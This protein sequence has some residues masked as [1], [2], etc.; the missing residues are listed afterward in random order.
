MNTSD[1]HIDLL[2]GGHATLQTDVPDEIAAAATVD[3]G[4]GVIVVSPEQSAVSA[5]VVAWRRT[6][7]DEDLYPV[8]ILSYIPVNEMGTKFEI[9]ILLPEGKTTITVGRER[10]SLVNLMRLGFVVSQTDRFWAEV[11]Y[12]IR[13]VRTRRTELYWESIIEG[14]LDVWAAVLNASTP[15]TVDAGPP[16]DARF[17]NELTSELPEILGKGVLQD[18][19]RLGRTTAIEEL[20]TVADGVM[21]TRTRTMN[22]LLESHRRLTRLPGWFDQFKLPQRS[23]EE[24]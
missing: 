1:I 17:I 24:L 21:L 16:I 5:L 4:L 23:V 18:A 20:T 7:A 9:A 8:P 15:F 19:R 11:E 12:V 14:T 22:L 13:M 6:D 2:N 3:F 10:M